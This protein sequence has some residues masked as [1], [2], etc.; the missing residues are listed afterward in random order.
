M[1]DVTTDQ[2]NP[3]VAGSP[4]EELSSRRD[5]PAILFQSSGRAIFEVPASGGTPLAA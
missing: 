1:Q 3:V 2:E 4:V 5:P